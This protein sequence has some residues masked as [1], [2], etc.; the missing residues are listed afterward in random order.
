MDRI[1]KQTQRWV[2]HCFAV[3][4]KNTLF[5]TDG[6]SKVKSRSKETIIRTD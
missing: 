5:K 4:K 6:F 2:I 1:N 3:D